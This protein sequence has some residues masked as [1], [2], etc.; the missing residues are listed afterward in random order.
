MRKIEELLN[1]EIE[2]KKQLH[3]LQ[4]QLDARNSED[5]VEA[6]SKTMKRNEADL[7]ERI[8][9]LKK[10]VERLKQLCRQQQ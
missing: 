5:K 8:E 6:L 3:E 9:S 4:M 10:E 7:N 2:Y 1:G